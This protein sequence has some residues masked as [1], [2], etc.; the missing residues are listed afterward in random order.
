MKLISFDVGIKN[1]AYCILE[2]GGGGAPGWTIHQWSVVSL[3][4][5]PAVLVCSSCP[6][7]AMWQ[8]PAPAG[9][10]YCKTH[11]TH[12]TT[13]FIPTAEN[14]WKTIKTQ[15]EVALQEWARRLKVPAVVPRR[16]WLKQIQQALAANTLVKAT[17]V[18]VENAQTLSL[19]EI[20]RRMTAA[21][22]ALAPWDDI[23]IVAI[24]NQI[25]P[26]ATRMKT[27]QGMITQYFIMRAPYARID[28]ISSVNK[29][30]EFGGGGT[31]YKT[32]K[33][34]SIV[35]GMQL[36]QEN[37]QLKPWLQ[38]VSLHKKKDDLFD[39]FLQGVYCITK[40]TAAAAAATPPTVEHAQSCDF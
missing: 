1:L 16:D 23:D 28:F 9:A 6:R 8:A 36:L 5:A 34:K 38:L 24:E 18:A 14:A 40:E 25:S 30:K 12:Q 31:T 10:L 7:R 13:F 2:T 19:V 22:D 33:Q 4:P 26:I 17:T 21:L 11:A 3:S 37:A 15:G 32:K 27:L 39:A 35:Q 29:L 20:G